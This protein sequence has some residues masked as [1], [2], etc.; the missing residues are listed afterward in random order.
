MEEKAS[1]EITSLRADGLLLRL[2]SAFSHVQPRVTPQT[3]AHQAPPPWILQAGA[4]EGVAIAFSG[5][6]GHV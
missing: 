6:D 5:A 3:A 4:L 1:Q 2:L